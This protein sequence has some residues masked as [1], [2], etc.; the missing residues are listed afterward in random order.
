VA[1][2]LVCKHVFIQLLY[3]KDLILPSQARDK[4]RE[5]SKQTKRFL[6][7]FTAQ[8]PLGP[9]SARAY[10]IGCQGNRGGGKPSYPYKVDVEN[11]PSAVGFLSNNS[12]ATDMSWS[13][14]QQN[15]E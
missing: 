11:C 9:W 5:N 10:D 15:G 12:A 4:H 8:H 13:G 14:A 6:T 2:Y 1:A 3:E 7:V